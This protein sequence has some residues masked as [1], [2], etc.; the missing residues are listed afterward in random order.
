MKSLSK[1]QIGI[2]VFSVLVFVLLYI[3]NK[4]PEKKATE[5]IAAAKTGTAKGPG[6]KVFVDTKISTLPDSLKKAQGVLA[7]KAEA[8]A[9]DNAGLDSLISF[10]DRLMQPDVAA[11]YTEK[12][13]ENKNTAEA[14]FRAGERY[15]YAVRFIKAPEEIGALY[16][17]AMSC[18]EKGLKMEPNNV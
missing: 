8:N 2:V 16:Q 7:K 4:T 9:K 1:L 11:Y 10:W 17:Q 13:A 5:D 15:F 18:F 14:W 6:I 12:I 3:A